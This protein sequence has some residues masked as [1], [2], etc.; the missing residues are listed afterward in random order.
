[1]TSP[2]STTPFS[3]PSKHQKV[4]DVSARP[5]FYSRRYKNLLQEFSPKK[6]GRAIVE[7]DDVREILQKTSFLRNGKL[8]LNYVTPSQLKAVEQFLLGDPS[9]KVVKIIIILANLV[10]VS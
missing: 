7:N 2:I 8:D 3:T 1:M 4:V 6:N 10:A 9:E 5:T